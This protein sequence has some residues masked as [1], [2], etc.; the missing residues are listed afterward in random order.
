MYKLIKQLVV[1]AIFLLQTN[2]YC[3]T[4]N[5][6]DGAFET[7]LVNSGIDTDGLINGY[8]LNADAEAIDTL[9]IGTTF[10]TNFT[11]LEAFINLKY[12]LIHEPY[13]SVCSFQTMDSL[14]ELYVDY[15]GVNSIDLS[16]NLLLKK[17]HCINSPV[18]YINITNN[19]NL[20][21]LELSNL[22]C[23]TID[24]SQ[25]INL[26]KFGSNNIGLDSINLS[27]NTLLNHL[28]CINDSLTE[29]DLT[30]NTL[31]K[32]VDLNHNL[33]TNLDLSQNSKINLLNL[34]YNNLPNIDLSHQD[35]LEYLYTRS[36][37]LTN[38]NLS[39]L[40]ELKRMVCDTNQIEILDLRYNP[41]LEFLFCSSNNLTELNIKNGNNGSIPNYSFDCRYNPNLTCIQVDNVQ[42]SNNTWQN[43]DVQSFFSYNCDYDLGYDNYDDT[44]INIYPN[45][46]AGIFH[47]F[48]DGEG[49]VNTVEIFDSLGKKVY[50]KRYNNQKNISIESNLP[51]GIYFLKIIANN[52]TQFKTLVV[53]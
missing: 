7:Y 29:I 28:I 46:N 30:H 41:L 20:E 8:I 3:Q 12:L 4:T 33:L 26:T 9:S 25:N 22:Q 51:A 6:P 52:R 39:N 32:Y 49:T 27:A 31:L 18:N 16:Q 42:Y 23:N 2:I 24:L 1:I 44:N 43:I 45:P 15:S 34:N 19:I 17:F 36:N 38:L 47:I 21:N 5:I 35:S 40:S 10:I 13:V 50:S 11:G 14:R 48:L 37:D 53:E